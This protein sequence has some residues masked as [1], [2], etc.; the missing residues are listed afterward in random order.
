M[1]GQPQR[2][3]PPELYSPLTDD[4]D[5]QSLISPI[6]LSGVSDSKQAQ[7]QEGGA[8]AN[9]PTAEGFSKKEQY[10]HVIVLLYAK[11]ME[12]LAKEIAM[13]SEGK[14]VL[15][16]IKWDRFPDSFPNIML[17]H[18]RAYK[19][20]H[21]AFLSSMH[22]PSVIF[23][24]ISAI[25]AIPKY[26]PKSFRIILPFFPT[27]TMERI[28]VQGEIATAHTLAKMLSVTPHCHTTPQ[29]V[30]FDIHALQNQFYFSDNV[31]V[32]LQSCASLLRRELKRMYP[33][34]EQASE[35]AIAFPD[36][37]AFK[38]FGNQF[39]AYAQI[40]CQKVR[41]NNRRIVTVKEGD[42]RG[43]HVVMVDDL[44]QSGGT[45]LECA[46]VIRKNGAKSVSSFVAHAIFP[47]NSWRK[48]VSKE[49]GGN[50]GPDEVVLDRFWISNS[51]PMAGRLVDTPP[52][53]VL[54]LS[55]IITRLLLDD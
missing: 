32:R 11:E 53:Q 17:Q 46:K 9:V 45:I 43:K 25:Y 30:I 42:I 13:H 24:Q 7:T 33:T 52:F 50:L 3:P 40:T 31:L 55:P 34:P 15:G 51:H 4:D 39:S 22:D 27:G 49:H 54:S 18:A 10:K 44:I 12:N 19:W 8:E 28:S 48:F 36:E 5:Y 20:A 21:I 23:E 1:Q 2:T 35:V 14:V 41:E 26:L 37:G 6:S 38:R 29:L 47:D 16:N